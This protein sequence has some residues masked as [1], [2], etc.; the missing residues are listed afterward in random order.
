MSKCTVQTFLNTENAQENKILTRHMLEF[1][2]LT[3]MSRKKFEFIFYSAERLNKGREISIWT[4]ALHPRHFAGKCLNLTSHSTNQLTGTSYFTNQLAGT[5]YFTNQ[6]DGTSYST[7]P[8]AWNQL[9]YDL[10]SEP[11]FSTNQC[12]ESASPPVRCL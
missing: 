6:L 1:T 12:L 7:K 2:D 3:S 5:S 11:S 9:L 10:V 4:Y 8:G